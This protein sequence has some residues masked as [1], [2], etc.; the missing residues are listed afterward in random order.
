MP[1]MR[2]GIEDKDGHKL[3]MDAD[4]RITVS[5]VG[6]VNTTMYTEASTARTTSGNTATQDWLANA[7]QC[8]VG[9]NLTALSGGTTPAV[10]VSLQQRDGNLVWHTLASTSALNAVGTAQ[11]SVGVGMTNGS[12]L[13]AGGQYRFSWTVTGTPTTCS[14]QIAMSGR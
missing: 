10:T 7:T 1:E 6:Q 13:M 5:T 3:E 12:M 2:V 14:F 11:F 9:V 4:G 8:W